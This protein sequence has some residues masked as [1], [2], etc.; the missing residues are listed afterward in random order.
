MHFLN[1]IGKSYIRICMAR[2]EV[3]VLICCLLA[4]QLLCAIPENKASLEK[5][6]ISFSTLKVGEGNFDQIHYLIGESETSAPLEFKRVRRSGPYSYFGPR[7]MQFI[8]EVPTP[9]PEDPMATTLKLLARVNIPKGWRDVLFFFEELNQKED[10]N[11][12]DLPYRVH[13]M[14]D[15][16]K[17][18]PAGSLVVFNA[19]GRPLLGSIGGVQNLYKAGPAQQVDFSHQSEEG[20]SSAFAIKTIDGPKLVFENSLDYSEQY[21]VILML[22]PPRR[23]SSIRIQVY[24]IPEFVEEDPLNYF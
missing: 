20:I 11:N 17:A 7:E 6:S 3:C 15:S 2:F 1:S 4:T 21:R 22:A 23:Q 12:V 8:R 18:F 13:M 19:T 24:S 16:L 5:V 10:A 14:N 9:T